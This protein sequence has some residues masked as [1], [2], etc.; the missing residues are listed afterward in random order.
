M[1]C[2]LLCDDMLIHGLYHLEILPGGAAEQTRSKPSKAGK[3]S[4][5]INSDEAVDLDAAQAVV[6][7]LNVHD[8][9]VLQRALEHV[10]TC[11]WSPPFK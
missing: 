9:K 1:L 7:K 10:N 3:K 2:R 8:L 4:E 6:R 11:V 5:A